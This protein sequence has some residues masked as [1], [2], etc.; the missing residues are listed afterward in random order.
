MLNL[1]G[2][3]A[4]GR[5]VPVIAPARAAEMLQANGALLVDVREPAELAQTGRLKGAINVPLATLAQRADPASPL[6]EPAFRTDR[7]VILYCASGKRSDA[8]GQALLG[9]G[10]DEVYN[11]GGIGAAAAAGL[12]VERG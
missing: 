1:F 3:G 7:P 5:K 8:G 6:H 4:G 10:Y 11:L 2:G 9:L 12:P